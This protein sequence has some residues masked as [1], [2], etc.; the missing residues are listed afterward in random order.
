VPL[1]SRLCA[2]RLEDDDV[3][4]LDR[5]CAGIVGL[6]DAGDISSRITGLLT[7]EYGFHMSWIGAPSADGAL[8]THTSG[9]RTER[10][11]GT[12][13]RNGR[14]LGGKVFASGRPAWVDD[15][16]G[17][18]D[19]THDYDEYVAAEQV[20]RMVAAPLLAEGRSFGVLLCGHRDQGSCG[21]RAIA[22]VEA[23][24]DRCARALSIA[25]R[26]RTVAELAVYEDRRQTALRLHERLG[27]MLLAIE[28]TARALREIGPSGRHRDER[29]QTLER[30][31]GDAA[32]L[33]GEWRHA[34]GGRRES[35][36]G[37]AVPIG[38]HSLHAASERNRSV[39]EP[40]GVIARRERDVLRRVAIGETNLEI[41]GAMSL[42]YNT[43]KTYLRNVM[44]KLGARNRVEAIAR[45][46][47]MGLL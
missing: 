2:G 37:S 35:L 46:R 36:L 17:S 29:L 30:L 18:A 22:I 34:G 24:A 13:L 40:G 8:I 38:Y 44:A 23:V 32:A 26:A 9:N 15:Y 4:R 21:D 45:A 12:L 14:G 20:Q 39:R 47:E 3:V 28:T 43:V 11:R 33:L 6:L 41:A 31:A 27:A 19:I 16:F 1:E 42:S 10:F 7:D 5:Q 25:D